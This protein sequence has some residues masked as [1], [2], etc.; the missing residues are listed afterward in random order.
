MRPPWWVLLSSALAPVLL[1]GGWTVA[2]MLQ[3][4][5][6]VWT[7]DTISALAGLG[8]SDRWIMTYAAAGLGICYM[9]TAV[10]LRAA[11]VLGRL[12]L[13]VGG[14]ATALVSAFPLPRTGVSD[15]HGLVALV[16]FAALAIWPLAGSRRGSEAGGTP[17]ALRLPVGI[18]ATVVL[19]LIA[20]WFGLSLL[21]HQFVG[22]SERFAA[23]A[24]AIWPL[25]V[26]LNVRA[27]SASRGTQP[28][29][30]SRAPRQ[31]EVRR[32]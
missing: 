11:A 26:V 30:T 20:G 10:A 6:Y 1:I 2:E 16:G 21:P 28:S 12:I 18:G 7:R 4:A 27:A 8:A 23:G 32:P 13:F 22:V 25:V 14:A 3:P 29:N 31:H 15:V 17:W 19:F 9:I 24:E 5:N